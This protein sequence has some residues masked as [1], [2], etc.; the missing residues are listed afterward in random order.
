MW[1]KF[2]HKFRIC[3]QFINFAVWKKVN[4]PLCHI[5]LINTVVVLAIIDDYDIGNM[6]LAKYDLPP[7]LFLLRG[8]IVVILAAV[9]LLFGTMQKSCKLCSIIMSSLDSCNDLHK[10][11]KF[12]SETSKC[13][14]VNRRRKVLHAMQFFYCQLLFE[15]DCS[16]Q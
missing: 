2:N 6:C 14:K 3:S 16:K 10:I 8:G 15:D 4:L 13:K 5:L 1:I 9:L 12:K 11:T 7:F